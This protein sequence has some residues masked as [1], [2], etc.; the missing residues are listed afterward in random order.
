MQLY[1]SLSGVRCWRSDEG[2]KA[3]PQRKRCLFCPRRQR[4]KRGSRISQDGPSSEFFLHPFAHTSILIQT[5]LTHE[6]TQVHSSSVTSICRT[7][8]TFSQLLLFL[9]ITSNL[10]SLPYHNPSFSPCLLLTVIT[11][12]LLFQLTCPRSR[13]TTRPRSIIPIAAYPSHLPKLQ[14]ASPHLV[15]PPTSHQR[16]QAAMQVAQASTNLA[17]L[18]LGL[19]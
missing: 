6:Q 19:I 14:R 5:Y 18:R 13:V 12:P 3:I 2:V 17:E 9:P 10:S 7:P 11:Q 1:L 15:S 16:P 4:Y 8:H